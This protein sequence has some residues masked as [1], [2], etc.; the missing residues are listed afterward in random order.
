M[1]DALCKAPVLFGGPAGHRPSCCR[2]CGALSET[3]CKTANEERCQPNNGA[4]QHRGSSDDCTTDRQGPSRPKFIAYPSA[5]KLKQ[6]VWNSKRG[7]NESKFRVA[8]LQFGLHQG[9]C[10]GNVRPID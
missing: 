8:E 5:E 2:E 9:R 3:Q 7:E 4:G 1:D 10:R 6:R